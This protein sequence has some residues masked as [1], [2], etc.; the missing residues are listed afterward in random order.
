MN[1]KKKLRL[2][3]F[4][5]LVLG[6]IIIFFTYYKKENLNDKTLLP[7]ATQEKLKEEI[8][9][10]KS[11]SG[12]VFF[13]ISYSGLDLAGNRYILKS[14]EAINSK[15]KKEIVFMKLVEAT[16]YFKD[17]TVL[18][19]WSDKGTY[20]NKTLDMIFDGNVKAIYEESELFAQ[21]ANY[22]NSNGFLT[23]SNDVKVKDPKG[24]IN[25]DKLLFDIK[26]QKLDIASFNDSKINANINLK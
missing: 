14:G 24:T 15:E 25:A 11:D 23:I 10:S 2:I 19:V 7:K 13:N 12:D 17:D 26:E 4:S 6:S 8:K 20:N 18:K 3:Q 9:K 16:F 22:S 21:K 5:L 1:R